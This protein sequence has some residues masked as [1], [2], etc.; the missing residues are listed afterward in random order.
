MLGQQ[1]D[2]IVY[3]VRPGDSL[4]RIISNYYGSVSPQKQQA[5]IA[6]IQKDNPKV[7]NP[8]QIVP[9]QLLLIDIPPQYCAV[10]FEERLIQPLNISKN[11]L[12]PLQQQWNK[13]APVTQERLATLTPLMLT[14]SQATMGTFKTVLAS[15]T[16]HLQTI[17][18]SY[19]AKKAGKLSKGQY[20]YARQQAIKRFETNLGPVR[21]LLNRH[22]SQRQVL[23]ISRKKGRS[24]TGNISQQI[25]RIGNLSKLAAGGGIVLAGLNLKMTC[26]AIEQA[27]TQLEKNQIFAETLGGILTSGAFGAVVYLVFAATPIG[28][29]VALVLAAGSVAYGSL[30]KRAS[31]YAYDTWGRKV[32]LLSKTGVSNICG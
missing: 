18:N 12:K 25:Q 7:T 32:D 6:Q 15:N 21:Y 29:S 22:Q 9:N 13:A 26:D 28:W 11:Q 16:Q 24:P 31:R 2:T 27:E 23:R 20:D 10:R 3:H 1:L 17:I 14:A 30:G 8:H 19:E 4:S 5:I